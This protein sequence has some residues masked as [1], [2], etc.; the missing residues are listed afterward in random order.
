M[1]LALLNGIQIFNLYPETN[2][3][4]N[5]GT[6]NREKKTL[7]LLNF[8]ILTEKKN[9][10]ESYKNVS[11]KHFQLSCSTNPTIGG[12]TT[13]RAVAKVQQHDLIYLTK[14]I[15]WLLNKRDFLN[16]ILILSKNKAYVNNKNN[17]DKFVALI[18]NT[19][20]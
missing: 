18:C 16:K 9:S 15:C 11:F 13:C 19:P 8:F 4:A 1:V 10:F 12:I 20:S 5:D 3:R 7:F 6:R 14:L 2:S 17:F